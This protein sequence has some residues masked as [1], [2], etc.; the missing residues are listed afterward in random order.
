MARNGATTGSTKLPEFVTTPTAA[1]FLAYQLEGLSER[2][3]TEAREA[4]Q[5]HVRAFE[6]RT[7]SR[8]AGQL[9]RLADR[10]RTEDE[11]EEA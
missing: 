5:E 11:D 1:D 9:R 4:G 2:A 6:L 10:L 3:T 7:L 8:A